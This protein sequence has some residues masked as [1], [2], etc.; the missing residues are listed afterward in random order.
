[1]IDFD[2]LRI[3]NAARADRWHAG[4]EEWTASDWSNA[5]AG[6]VGEACNVVKKVRR[7]ETNIQGVAVNIAECKCAEL[8]SSEPRYVGHVPGCPAGRP[9]NTPATEELRAML[10]DE[11][12][13]VI[14]YADLLARHFAIDVESAVRDKFNRVSEAQGFPERL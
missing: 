14:L 7:H 2:T 8:D 13:D 1:M 10:A 3:Q 4:A 9:Y 11:I 12:A 6:E 5:L